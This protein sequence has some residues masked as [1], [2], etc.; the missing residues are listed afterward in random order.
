[1]SETK[2]IHPLREVVL[3]EVTARQGTEISPHAFWLA[4]EFVLHLACSH[5]QIRVKDVYGATHGSTLETVKA[6]LPKRVRCTECDGASVVVKAAAKPLPKYDPMAVALGQA[7]KSVAPEREDEVLAWIIENG[8]GFAHTERVYSIVAAAMIDIFRRDVADDRATAVRDAVLAWGENPNDDT[9]AQ[10][11]RIG[12]RLYHAQH[13]VDGDWSAVRGIIEARKATPR[14]I[15]ESLTW[16]GFEREHFM[17]KL[18]VARK[19][20]DAGIGDQAKLE[21]VWTQEYPEISVENIPTLEH[22]MN[23]YR[24]ARY[25]ACTDCGVDTWSIRESA[26]QLRPSV[27][28]IAYPGYNRG[29]GVGGSRPCIGCLE[30]R[31]GRV[32]CLADFTKGKNSINEP[33]AARHSAKL[34]Q[35]LTS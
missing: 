1:M 13:R 7:L 27:W 3:V 19:A 34:I 10:S 28:E 30:K 24:E 32:L 2:T 16:G 20:Y 4:R 6:A 25:R 18:W 9:R 23:V 12:R 11:T 29:V 15:L 35:R 31:L 8:S 5:K 22:L 14:G 26:Y 21:R 17:K 33:D